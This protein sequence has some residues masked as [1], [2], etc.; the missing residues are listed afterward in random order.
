MLARAGG[1][2]DRRD[3]TTT[4]QTRIIRELDADNER[5]G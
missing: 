3:R 5:D 2:R 4:G 1:R